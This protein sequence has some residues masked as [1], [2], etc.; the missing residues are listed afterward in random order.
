MSVFGKL[1]LQN[2]D[3]NTATAIRAI[4]MAIFLMGVFIFEGNLGEIP[5]IIGEKLSLVNVIGI[6]LIALGVII[7]AWH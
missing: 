3:A 5:V 4:I 2:I 7:T 1:G 6:A